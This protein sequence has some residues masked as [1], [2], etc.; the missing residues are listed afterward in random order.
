MLELFRE[1][2]RECEKDGEMLGEKESENW[3]KKN[4]KLYLELKRMVNTELHNPLAQK[5][6]SLLLMNSVFRLFTCI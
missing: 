5:K 1:E 6:S 3:R 4:K 2:P